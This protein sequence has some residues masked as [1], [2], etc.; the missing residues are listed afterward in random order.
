MKKNFHPIYSVPVQHSGERFEYRVFGKEWQV[1]SQGLIHVCLCDTEW[2]AKSITD[3]LNMMA[4]VWNL[5]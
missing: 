3:A 2:A 1:Y 4:R 5:E